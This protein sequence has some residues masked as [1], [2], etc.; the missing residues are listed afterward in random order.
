MDKVVPEN[1]ELMMLVLLPT[2]GSVF[3]YNKDA[4]KQIYVIKRYDFAT[5]ETENIT[6]GPGGAARPQL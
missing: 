1:L 5:G 4:N 2:S 3:E 6:G